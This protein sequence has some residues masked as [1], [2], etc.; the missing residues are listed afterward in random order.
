[1]ANVKEEKV[2]RAESRAVLKAKKYGGLRIRWKIL[3]LV[4]VRL[5]TRD[6]G[7]RHLLVDEAFPP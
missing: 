1:M 4:I 3:H 6:E 2:Y 5:R 7:G